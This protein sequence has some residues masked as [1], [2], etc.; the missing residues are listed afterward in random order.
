MQIFGLWSLKV[1]GHVTRQKYSILKPILDQSQIFWQEKK[2]LNSVLHLRP[3]QV[4]FRV[5]EMDFL[6][7]LCT[8]VIPMGNGLWSVFS[9]FDHFVSVESLQFVL[10]Q[11]DIDAG[12]LIQLFS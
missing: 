5:F 3:F 2:A 1:G 8:C 12:H 9:H 11:K 4:G 10:S 7:L 6:D